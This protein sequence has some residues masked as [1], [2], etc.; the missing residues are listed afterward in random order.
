MQANNWLKRM[1]RA[2]VS[3]KSTP[4]SFAVNTEVEGEVLISASET[5]EMETPEENDF[6][7]L[8]MNNQQ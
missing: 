2:P 6:V 3:V 5:E 8:Q 7:V 4:R 1:Y